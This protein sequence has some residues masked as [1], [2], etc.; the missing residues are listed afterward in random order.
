M[1][2]AGS[3]PVGASRITGAWS[4]GQ[5]T[6]LLPQ[7]IAVRIRARLPMPRRVP[8]ESGR[9]GCVIPLNETSIAALEVHAAWYNRRF[10]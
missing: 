8:P 4:N 5:G 1:D 6:E 3:S 10:W 7:R 9:H 2:D